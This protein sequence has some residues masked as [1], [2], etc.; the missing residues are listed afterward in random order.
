MAKPY[1]LQSQGVRLEVYQDQDGDWC[2]EVKDLCKP[3]TV[4]DC[5][6][7][8]SFEEAK[9]CGEQAYNAVLNKLVL[10]AFRI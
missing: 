8:S 10:A 1:K 7:L 9:L 5:S 3:G 4:E 2:Y 6:A